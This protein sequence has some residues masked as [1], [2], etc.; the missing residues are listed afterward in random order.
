VAREIGKDVGRLRLAVDQWRARGREQIASGGLRLRSDSLQ[1]S[2]SCYWH[3]CIC[4]SLF[5]LIGDNHSK[6]LRRGGTYQ[7]TAAESFP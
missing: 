6:H 1:V 5:F 7:R 2:K 3:G 4:A